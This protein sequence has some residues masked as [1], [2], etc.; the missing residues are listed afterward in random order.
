MPP[1]PER[2]PVVRRLR[3]LGGRPAVTSS[4]CRAPSGAS[5]LTRAYDRFPAHG[6]VFPGYCDVQMEPGCPF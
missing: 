1:G 2:R 3:L 4:H 6:R 5:Q